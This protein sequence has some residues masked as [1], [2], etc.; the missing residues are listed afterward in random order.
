MNTRSSLWQ[1]FARSKRYREEFVAAQVKR[2]IPFQ[3][4][5]VLKSRVGW[6]QETLAENA[7]LT[8]G[9]VSR[10]LD[11]NYG[12]LTLNTVI[13]I[14]AGFDVAFI[15]KFVPFSELKD[16]F[17]ALSEESAI[18]SSFAEENDALAEVGN[19][20]SIGVPQVRS[21][22]V[23][24]WERSEGQGFSNITY[25]D[26]FKKKQAGKNQGVSSR[27]MFILAGGQGER[28]IHEAVG[29]RSR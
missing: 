3:A 25:I 18:V 5:A 23:S 26:D 11:P 6:T 1:K 22:S 19:V 17:L 2:G 16:W 24:V 29:S 10:A 28:G 9:V 21:D 13:R 12:N 27:S 14:A 4:R 15:G 8:Q 20:P 7:G